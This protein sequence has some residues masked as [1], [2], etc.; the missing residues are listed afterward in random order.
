M[1]RKLKG[2]ENSQDQPLDGVSAGLEVP[3]GDVLL[4]S[5]RELPSASP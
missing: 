3:Y 5:P 4:A 1:V 2:S